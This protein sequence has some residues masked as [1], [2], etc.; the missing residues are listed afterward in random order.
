M[1]S[2]QEP[3]TAGCPWGHAG[4]IV[5]AWHLQV[6]TP[7]KCLRVKRVRWVGRHLSPEDRKAAEKGL[8]AGVFA[9]RPA[10]GQTRHRGKFEDLD[11]DS[12][13]TTDWLYGR[14]SCAARGAHASVR[15]QC[16]VPPR[17][18]RHCSWAVE[19]VDACG[20][21]F[22]A[23]LGPQKTRHTFPRQTCSFCL[24]HT[25]RLPDER[26]TGVCIPGTGS[27]HCCPHCRHH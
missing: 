26:G 12:L 16:S 8:A 10:A 9:G 13:K 19:S 3:L 6:F 22:Q 5:L 2:H 18:Q 25:D 24:R 7:G 4:L 17:T 1:F 21:H 14:W 20:G 15:R 11:I 27:S 23:F